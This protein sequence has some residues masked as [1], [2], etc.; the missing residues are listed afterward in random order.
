M[1]ARVKYQKGE[2]V[3]YVG[4][5]DTMRTF[6]RCLKRTAIPVEYSKG[7]NPRVQISFALPLGVGITSESEYFDLLVRSKMNEDIFL[8][9]LN[10]VLP[11]GFRATQVEYLEE[12]KKSLMAQVKE[13]VYEI[14]IEGDFT[15]S[16]IQELLGR[17]KIIIEKESNEKHKVTEIDLKTYLIETEASPLEEGKMLVTVHATAGSVNNFNP[18]FLLQAVEKYVGHVEDYEIH[19][20]ELILKK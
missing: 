7:F 13:A 11:V 18:Q 6:I 20:K 19:R 17:E 1:R 15:I 10:S 14:T 9:E 16:E 12:E 2:A 5:L 3:K 4:H 8:S